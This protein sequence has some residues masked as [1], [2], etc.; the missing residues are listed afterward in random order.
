MIFSRLGEYIYQMGTEGSTRLHLQWSPKVWHHL[1][2]LNFH[3]NLEIIWGFSVRLRSEAKRDFLNI[4]ARL[5]VTNMELWKPLQ[6]MEQLNL[7]IK[8]DH[9]IRRSSLVHWE[10]ATSLQIEN[11]LNKEHS[12]SPVKRRWSCRGLR[13]WAAGS[14]Q[15]LR[16]QDQTLRVD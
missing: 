7:K 5:K 9:I 15:L 14:K 10:T 13:G 8:S 1:Q 11:F 6:K 12:E 4:T 3:V 2:H 16:K